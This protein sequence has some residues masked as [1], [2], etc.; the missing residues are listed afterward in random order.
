M[1]DPLGDLTRVGVAIWLDD[2]SRARLASSSNATAPMTFQTSWPAL[3]DILEGKLAA[4]ERG[5]NGD[6]PP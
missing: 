2:V 3:T 5:G 4:A 1:A 6:D